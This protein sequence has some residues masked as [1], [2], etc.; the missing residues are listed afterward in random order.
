MSATTATLDRSERACYG[1]SI[2]EVGFVGIALTHPCTNCTACIRFTDDAAIISLRC[3]LL[4]LLLLLLLLCLDRKDR[5]RRSRL[6]TRP[7]VAGPDI[8]LEPS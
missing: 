6:D 5:R 2:N 7:P 8:V 4:L 3:N 1:S